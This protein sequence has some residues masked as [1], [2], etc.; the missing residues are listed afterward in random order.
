MTVD[1]LNHD[2]RAFFEHWTRP[3]TDYELIQRRDELRR[4]ATGNKLGSNRKAGVL[5]LTALHDLTNPPQ[6][7]N[8]Y[9]LAIG[10][11]QKLYDKGDDVTAARVLGNDGLDLRSLAPREG[12]ADFDEREEACRTDYEDKRHE[13]LRKLKRKHQWTDEEAEKF[14]DG[15]EDDQK[16]G[17]TLDAALRREAN[18][19]HMFQGDR[20]ICWLIAWNSLGLVCVYYRQLGHLQHWNEC[21]N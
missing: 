21:P 18:L 14:F 8:P 10:I 17:H 6:E 16:R 7:S 4:E 1:K 15:D 2:Q 13:A 19:N 9:E 12:G 11:A 5:A 3:G 20:D